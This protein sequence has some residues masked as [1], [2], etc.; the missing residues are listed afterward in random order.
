VLDIMWAMT[1]PE[2]VRF[3][4]T[5]PS[6]AFP[7]GRLLAVRA[8]HAHV[9]APDGWDHVGDR[10]P[11]GATGLSRE[12]AEV[13]CEREGWHPALLDRVPTN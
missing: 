6:M 1:R 7:R 9:L 10:G 8:G 2:P 12:E 3:L 13:W 11:V 4:R 5:E